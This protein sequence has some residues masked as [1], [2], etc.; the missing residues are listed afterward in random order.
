MIRKWI[1]IVLVL[2][3]AL[4]AG[5]SGYFDEYYFAEFGIADE[6]IVRMDDA[7]AADNDYAKFTANG[8][9]GRSYAE[10]L[11]DLSGQAAAAFGWNSQ[12]LTGIG[13]LA[14]GAH[15]I[16][17]S[18]DE[19]QLTITGNA[20]QTSDLFLVE[21]SDG[22]DYFHVEANGEI[23]I[24]HTA[25]ENDDRTL[26]IDTD[27][28]GLGDIK[29]VDINYITGAISAGDDEAVILVNIDETAA[30]GGEIFALEVLATDGSA[31]IFGLKAGVLVGPVHQDSGTFAN[32]AIGT[33]DTPTTAV[34][35]MIDGDSGPTERTSI[36]IAFDDYIIIGATA[37]FQEMEFIITTGS[38][39]AGI[40]PKFEYS[41]GGSGFTVFSPVD[42]TNGFRNT[43]VVAWDA[44]DL[45][46]HAVN[47]DTGA[48]NTYDIRITR[49]RN[50]LGTTPILG[51]A[52][53]AATTEY[54]WDKNGDVIVKSVTAA[55]A[56]INGGS[57]DAATLGTNSDITEAQIDNIN[58]NGNTIDGSGN[59]HL[60]RSTSGNITIGDGGNI[61][62]IRVS[63]QGV[64]NFIG[65]AGYSYISCK[66]V[67]LTYSQLMA[68]NTQYTISDAAMATGVGHGPTHDGNG[69]LTAVIQGRYWIS[70][71]ATLEC[72]TLISTKV[73]LEIDG[74]AVTDGEQLVDFL[75][76]DKN[77][78]AAGSAILELESN[79]KITVGLY[80]TD[81]S[82]AE[83]VSVNNL[84]LT[85]VQIG[86]NPS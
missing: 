47:A 15:T 8:L 44:S 32:P 19:V 70:W 74:G 75:V 64:T 82:G 62:Y 40:K 76:V 52:K 81:A 84:G 31:A 18:A 54:V 66:G 16:T 46:G 49:E 60:T 22:T 17:G 39:G 30:G 73:G 69:G 43:G 11:S 79:E 37:V 21:K 26:K 67:S 41:T 57:I 61:H 23:H 33:N 28:A 83:T 68:V 78:P 45:A 77:H 80:S 42:G 12:N 10:V 85:I 34:P 53:T 51:Y 29:S 20:T 14:S 65:N 2:V 24:E 6:N 58:I 9:E 25:N 55:T 1:A 27:G 4:P 3:W 13:S 50:N 48:A 7:D 5:V 56:D 86:G 71:Y 63:S 35:K 72:D 36:F 59:L 38:S